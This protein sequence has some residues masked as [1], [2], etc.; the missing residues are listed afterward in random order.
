MRVWGPSLQSIVPQETVSF[1]VFY[2]LVSVDRK[3]ERKERVIVAA[4]PVFADAK[5]L[6]KAAIVALFAAAGVGASPRIDVEVDPADFALGGYR[7][8]AGY[9][10]ND[11]MRFDVGVLGVE[12][13]RAIHG[14]DRFAW[15][16]SGVAARADYLFGS[17]EGWFAGLEGT[18]M[19]DIYTHLA[20][21]VSETRRPFLLAARAGYRF[22][23][24]GHL[25]LTP[26]LGSGALL[27]KGDDY[28]I[29]EGDKFEV[30]TFNVFPT[31]HVGWAF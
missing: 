21:G 8:H 22:V 29:V 30:R 26:W 13:P 24:R 1:T 11:F 16:I 15:E 18:W 10:H 7:I 5:C 25:T 31:I 17:Y 3:S 12:I 2:D 6:V 28:V 9:I 23:F 20:S 19:K 4:L 27:N 14:N